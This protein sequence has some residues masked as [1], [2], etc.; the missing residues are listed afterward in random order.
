MYGS[1][2]T[3]ETEALVERAKKLPELGAARVLLHDPSSSLE[4]YRA[5]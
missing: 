2:Y 3:G 1:G 5:H 4:P